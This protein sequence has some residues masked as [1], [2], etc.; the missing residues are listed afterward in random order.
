MKTPGKLLLLLAVLSECACGSSPRSTTDWVDQLAAR[1]TA[2]EVAAVIGTEGSSVPGQNLPGFETRAGERDQVRVTGTF[3]NGRAVT[4]SIRFPSGLRPPVPIGVLPRLG[5]EATTF[6]EVERICGGAGM[7]Q[8][9]VLLAGMLGEPDTLQETREWAIFDGAED[10]GDR[11]IVHFANERVSLVEFPRSRIRPGET[12]AAAD[13]LAP[14]LSTLNLCELVPGTESASGLGGELKETQ[15]YTPSTLSRCVYVVARATAAAARDNTAQLVM[16]P[17]NRYTSLMRCPPDAPIEKLDGL[18]DEGLL[19]RDQ[20]DG[21]TKVRLLV[22]GRFPL[23]A[24]ASR[25]DAAR[26]LAEL[27]LARLPR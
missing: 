24:N 21:W 17:S 6:P 25:A 3:S 9:R 8:L 14:D 1:M 15:T 12:P 20:C 27:A 2:E 5:E 4:L 19:L 11:L 23:D 18:A 16:Y 26:K 7:L 10:T 22:R 13:P